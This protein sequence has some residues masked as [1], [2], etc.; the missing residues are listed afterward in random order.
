MIAEAGF[1]GIDISAQHPDESRTLRPLMTDAGLGCTCYAFPNSV[2][3]FQRDI[4]LALELEAQHL[5]LIIQIFPMTVGEGT[6]VI[7]RLLEMGK[8]SGMPLTV[9]THRNAIT[10]DLLYTLQLID[11]LPEMAISADLSHYV[12]ER[13]FT[14]PVPARDEAWMQQIIARAVAF[15]GRI[16]SRE[17]IQI[18]LDFPQHQDWVAK[19]LQWWEDGMRSWR[20]R[21][22]DGA[23]LNFLTQLGPPPYA[24]T[25][26][27]GYELSDRWAEAQVIKD[28]VRDIWQRLEVESEANKG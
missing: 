12:V 26:R 28:W 7:G 5:N 9:E 19:H 1:D 16:A 10:T 25:G 21:S 4:D 2:E 23:T 3:G 11:G 6:E 14:W 27:D 20:D 15:Q 17:Q 22:P 18:Q 8:Q 24:I 13:E